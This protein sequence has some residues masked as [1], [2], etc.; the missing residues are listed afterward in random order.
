MSVNL[1]VSGTSTNG[2]LNASWVYRFIE[3]FIRLITKFVGSDRPRPWR[4]ERERERVAAGWRGEKAG[5]KRG[6]LLRLLA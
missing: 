2:W 5:S 1:F 4:G 6:W 3:D